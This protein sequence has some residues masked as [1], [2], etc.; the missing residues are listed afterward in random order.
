[1]TKRGRPRKTVE[2]PTIN[3]AD[4]FTNDA[5]EEIAE[6][7]EDV[8]DEVDNEIEE[9]EEEIEEEVKKESRLQKL[10]REAKEKLKLPK[11]SV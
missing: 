2:E 6:P 7:E 4:V 9:F 5:D 1:M 10:R 8:M 3:A 11:V